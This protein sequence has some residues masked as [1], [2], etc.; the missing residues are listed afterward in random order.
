MGKFTV[1]SNLGG[2]LYGGNIVRDI[3]LIDAKIELLTKSITALTESLPELQTKLEDAEIIATQALD[4]Y[5]EYVQTIDISSITSEQYKTVSELYGITANANNDVNKWT[6][7][8]SIVNLDVANKQKEVDKLNIVKNKPYYREVWCTDKTTNLNIGNTYDSIELAGEIESVLITPQ[9]SSYT[10]TLPARLFTPTHAITASQTL[11]N[12]MAF[13]AWQKHKPYYRSAV[14]TSVSGDNCNVL[15]DSQVSSLLSA[16]YGNEIN[17]D[18]DGLAKTNLPIEYMECD[19]DVF[20]TGDHVVVEFSGSWNSGKVIGFVS[21]PKECDSINWPYVEVACHIEYQTAAAGWTNYNDPFRE[22]EDFKATAFRFILDEAPTAEGFTYS[23]FNV[24]DPV[25]PWIPFA[26]PLKILMPE[27]D[28]KSWLEWRRDLGDFVHDNGSPYFLSTDD[29]DYGTVW[30]P[31]YKFYD[32]W[33]DSGGNIKYSD[34]GLP[35]TINENLLPELDPATLST[36][37]AYQYKYSVGDGDYM[38]GTCTDDA[39]GTTVAFTNWPVATN[40]S[41]VGTPNGFKVSIVRVI[42]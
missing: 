18:P 29:P 4:D 30:F 2:G 11:Y 23:G 12:I 39:S 38:S 17:I 5:I 15:L 14:I 33:L 6:R 24:G 7:E 21:N 26:Q 22:E 40:R 13:A 28:N 8:I 31:L 34:G 27:L 3:G 41:I 16:R 36:Y 20:E 42:T 9:Y 25:T 19:G 10:P 1:S 37:E 35:I 32:F